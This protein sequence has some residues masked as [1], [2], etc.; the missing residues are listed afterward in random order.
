MKPIGEEFGVNVKNLRIDFGWSQEF[1]AEKC[2]LDRTTIILIEKG[3]SNVT[4]NTLATIADVLKVHP[5]DLLKT[6]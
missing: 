3:L 1:L 4:L 5:S 6:D 2:D